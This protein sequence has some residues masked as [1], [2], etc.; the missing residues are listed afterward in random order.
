[1][2][3][4]DP[5]LFWL[6]LAAFL[7][8][9]ASRNHAFAEEIDNPHD[10]EESCIL[11]HLEHPSKGSTSLKFDGAEQLCGHCH[12]DMDTHHSIHPTDITPSTRLLQN[13]Q[14]SFQENIN[15]AENKMGCLVCHDPTIQCEENVKHY[16]NS[17]KSFLRGEPY[18]KPVDFCYQCHRRAAYQKLNPHEQ[19]DEQGDVLKNRCLICHTSF[20]EEEGQERVSKASLKSDLIDICNNCHKTPNHPSRTNHIIKASVGIRQYMEQ[21]VRDLNVYLPL[22]PQTGRIYCATCHYS[23]QSGIVKSERV[24]LGAD[25]QA[26][27]R[28]TCDYCHDK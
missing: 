28:S 20:P 1:M 26:F 22:E 27:V 10:N 19:T 6:L 12:R 7:E 21:T 16:A 15:L 13:M 17:S 25:S 5:L 11:C 8:F 14:K 23:H 3:S 4:F 9:T 2:K 18:N 24:A